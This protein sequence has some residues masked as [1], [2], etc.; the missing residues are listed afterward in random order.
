M[1]ALLD[2]EAR[3]DGPLFTL[4]AGDVADF[5]D[6]SALVDATDFEDEDLLFDTLGK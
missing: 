3:V 1:P 5:A 6:R 4:F 2:V